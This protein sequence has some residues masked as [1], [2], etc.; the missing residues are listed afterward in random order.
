[1]FK[2]PDHARRYLADRVL[3]AFEKD[4]L[5]ERGKREMRGV[6]GKKWSI[7]GWAVWWWAGSEEKARMKMER[8]RAIE[9]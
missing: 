3:V 6:W 5:R 8:L 9:Q 2:V 1:L 4:E 7:V